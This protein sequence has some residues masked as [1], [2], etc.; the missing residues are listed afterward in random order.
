MDEPPLPLPLWVLRRAADE[1]GDINYSGAAGSTWVRFVRS[2][3]Q[4]V[5]SRRAIGQP[6]GTSPDKR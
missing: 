5:R 6:L 4:L 2:L 1:S 3:V